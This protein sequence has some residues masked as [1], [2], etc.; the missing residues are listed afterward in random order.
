MAN[1]I[2]LTGKK[3]SA[4]VFVSNLIVVNKQV[5]YLTAYGPTQEVRAFAQLLASGEA[6]AV[7][8]ENGVHKER[9]YNLSGRDVRF[10]TDLGNGYSG[11]FIIPAA[12][13]HLLIG[14]SQAECYNI[15]SLILD[16]QEFV[17]RDWYP[18]MFSKIAKE[19]PTTLGSKRCWQ[20]HPESIPLIIAEAL[21]WDAIMMP[22]TTAHLVVE[23]M[24][25]KPPAA[26]L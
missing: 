18:L 20:Y 6:E 11:V 12:D 15:F 16:Q 2:A 4:T 19:I 26:A 21:K 9:I 3:A 23:T 17:H 22:P 8:E 1:H 5:R 7:I 13:S 24:E 25:T 14:N 10:V